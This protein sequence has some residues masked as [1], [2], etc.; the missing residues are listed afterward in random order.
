MS[1]TNFAAL[2][3]EQKAVWSRD[4]WHQAR[5]VSF[6]NRFVG[7]GSNSMVQRITELTKTER[8]DRAVITLTT[9][10]ENDGVVGDNELE[11]NEGEISAYDKVVR[12]D[13]LR[14]A[15]RHK[16][17]MSQQRSVVNFRETAKD[18][19]AYWLADRMDQLAFLTLSGVS[20]AYKTNGAARTDSQL[21]LLD[22][23]ADVTAP[24]TNRYRNWDASAAALIAGDTATIAADDV[25]SY[26][27]IASLKAYAK[28]NFI[29]GIREKGGEE[30]YHLFL[31]PQQMVQLKLDSDYLAN[32]RNAGVRGKSNELF[33][34]STSVLVDGVWVHEYRH[35][36]NTSG[37]ATKWG[38]GNAID[39]ARALF[40]GAQALALCDLGAPNWVE[41][42]HDYENQQAIAIDKIVGMLKPV[43]RSSVTATDEDFGVV[44]VNTS[45]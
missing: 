30:V 20:Y 17:R 9:E 37:T 3:T 23:A 4:L 39:G 33:A 35:V 8:G 12:I 41:E 11:G 29:R 45:Y 28:D 38:A 22:F 43:F 18:A 42:G 26:K 36:Y 2:T 15:A 13:Q 6:L 19:L 40:C 27:M 5:N 34:G 10:L 31:T 24:S 25:P 21:S 1:L 44:A 32:I 16:G 14:N 7:K